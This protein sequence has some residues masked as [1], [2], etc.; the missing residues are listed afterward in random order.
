MI[1]E[2][3]RLGTRTVKNRVVAAGHGTGLA[4]GTFS[5]ELNAYMAAR[6]A[7]GAGL[8]SEAFEAVRDLGA[9]VP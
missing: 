3:L 6:A 4:R 8:M 2:P 5:P 7:G 1:V 9:F